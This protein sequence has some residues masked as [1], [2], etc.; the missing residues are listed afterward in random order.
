MICPGLTELPEGTQEYRRDLHPD[1]I[2]SAA[3]KELFIE[4]NRLRKHWERRSR[5]LKRKE[6][7]QNS[8]LRKAKTKGTAKAANRG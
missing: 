4:A 3:Y 7:R 1:G 5:Y 8:C 6:K 2:S